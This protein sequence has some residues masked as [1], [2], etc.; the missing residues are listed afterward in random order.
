MARRRHP[1]K[2]KSHVWCDVHCTV[3]GAVPD[4]YDEGTVDCRR[5][6]WRP[7]YVLAHNKEEF[8]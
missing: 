4:F 8:E 3:H 1:V 5:K 7:V 6:N 2:I